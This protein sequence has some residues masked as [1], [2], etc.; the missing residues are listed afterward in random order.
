MRSAAGEITIV[1]LAL[2]GSVSAVQADAGLPILRVVDDRGSVTLRFDN[3][4]EYP[5]YDFYLK[6]GEGPGDPDASPHLVAIRSG[7]PIQPFHGSRW[8][9]D[10][11][12]LAVPHGQKQPVV[13]P[14]YSWM[15]EAPPGCLQSDGLE[16]TYEGSGYLVP[17]RV[18]IGAGVLE[19][20]RQP[21]EWLP[22][23]WSLWWLKRLPCI[24]VP[25]AFCAALGWLGARIAR[26]MFPPRPA[27][28]V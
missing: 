13:S 10:V 19:V 22:S 28:T 4:A 21:T 16:G 26:R 24:A 5:D 1:V 12:L 7:E 2:V 11:Y 6:Y 18:R 23:E 15:V 9:T 17:Y 3:L 27:R 14:G 20:N 8:R 25:V